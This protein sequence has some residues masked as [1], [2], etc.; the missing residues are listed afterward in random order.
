MLGMFTADP[1]GDGLAVARACVNYPVL[2]G[3]SITHLD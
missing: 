2:S 1:A 3:R